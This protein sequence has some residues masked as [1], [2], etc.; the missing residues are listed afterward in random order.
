MGFLSDEVTNSQGSDYVHSFHSQSSTTECGGG[1]MIPNYAFKYSFFCHYWFAA[2]NKYFLFSLY[3]FF[4]Y[5]FVCFLLQTK[6]MCNNAHFHKNTTEK[7]LLSTTTPD[8]FCLYIQDN[9]F[10]L[11]PHIE[12]GR[13]KSPYDPK[14]LTA[15]M[16]IGEFK[17]RCTLPLVCV[18]L[19][20][21]IKT[22]ESWKHPLPCSCIFADTE[23][24]K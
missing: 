23:G 8:V 11:E 20:I 14:L 1:N 13:G 5:F 3:D 4:S 19:Q 10:R 2:L 17:S 9:V 15:S 21:H 18:L 12:N 16:L 7:S 24:V 22:S 6:I